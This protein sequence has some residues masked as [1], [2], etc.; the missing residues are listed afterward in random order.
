MILETHGKRVLVAFGTRP[1]ALKFVP[2]IQ[3]LKAAPDFKCFVCL[4]GQHRRILNQVVKF[5]KIDIDADLRLMRANQ[6]LEDL[7]GRVIS[8]FAKIINKIQPEI[9]FVLGD[10]V[11]ALMCAMA[12]F[13]AGKPIAHL[14][15]GLRTR[16][17]F[18]PFPEEMN[19]TL[20]SRL[21]DYHFTPTR[22]ATQN[23]VREG[24]SKKDIFQVGNTIIDTLRIA[25]PLVKSNYPI[26]KGLDSDKRILFVTVHRC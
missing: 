2:L 9:V 21:A 17:K 22:V 25:A 13:Y 26:F 11:T 8:R 14:E 12:S 15:A 3:L 6:A 24:V 18:A 20:L 7:S 10:T 23:L 4:T 1:E 19:R 16:H 5:F